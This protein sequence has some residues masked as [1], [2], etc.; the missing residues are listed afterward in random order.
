L[1]P[2]GARV[3]ER[4]SRPVTLLGLA[5]AMEVRV[6]AKAKMTGRRDE[7]CMVDGVTDR[8]EGDD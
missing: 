8:H 1:L 3:L 6:R 7:R 2:P 5:I 4:F